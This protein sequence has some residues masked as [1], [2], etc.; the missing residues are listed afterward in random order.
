MIDFAY[1]YED[2]HP[3]LIASLAAYCGDLDVATEAADEA[4]VRALEK[5]DSVAATENPQGWVFRVAVNEV[6]RRHRR[7]SI[8]RR[9]LRRSVRPTSIPGPAGEIWSVVADLGDRQRQAVVLR[10]VAQ[11][12]EPEIAEVMGVTRGT[13]SSTL[14]AA[15]QRLRASV[16]PQSIDLDA[17]GGGHSNGCA[18]S[19]PVAEQTNDKEVR[20]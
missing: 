17:H 2:V 1:F 10:H 11:M 6:K 7:Q 15:H 9:V 16:D 20:P 19:H 13:V 18:A 12:S 14:R 4:S 8:E 3:R 5:W